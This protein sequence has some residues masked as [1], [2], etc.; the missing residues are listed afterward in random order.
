M[1]IDGYSIN[2]YQWL[3]M[4]ILVVDISVINGYYI[5]GY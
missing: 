1:T 5:S 3:L 2:A 4:D